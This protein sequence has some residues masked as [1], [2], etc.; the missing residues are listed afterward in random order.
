MNAAGGPPRPGALSTAAAI[1][2]TL[3]L[4]ATAWSIA[5]EGIAAALC[6]VLTLA[7]L[8]RTRT[9]WPATPVNLAGIG[10]FVALLVV[11][12]CSLDRAHSLPVITK[13]L[14]PLLVGLGAIHGRD[15]RVAE[16]AV[17]AYF[18]AFAIASVAGFAIWLSQ[19]ASFELRAR[20]LSGHYMTYAGQ[21]TLVLP[22]AIAI[23]VCDTR[24]RWRWGAGAT[25]AL[26]AVALSVTFTRSAWIALFVAGSVIA[27]AV[28]PLGLL[29][30][31]VLAGAAFAFAPGAWHER[32]WS[33][34]DPHHPA[35]QQRMYM[36][37]AGVRMFRDHPLTGV[38]LQ[39][40]HPL[41][42]RYRS[43][44]STER[45]GHLHNVYVQIAA[46]M[47]LVGL[48]AFAWLYG[49]FVRAASAGLRAQLKGRGFAAGL[50]L[51]VLASLAGFLVAGAFEWNFGSE[52]LL[53]QLYTLVGL[54][55]AARA[56]DDGQ[57]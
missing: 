11:S 38:G 20:G 23:A 32:L 33:I 37:D 51:G 2:F 43:P 30:L 35:N 53:Y 31:A 36:W 13:G 5:P 18:A 9:P 24:P 39:D 40:L 10:W 26:A 21:L 7:M 28:W 54:A 1:A 57:G 16:R 12:L 15:R 34:F 48:A 29:V 46:Q 44:L 27:G 19:G 55:W 4:V 45:A 17:A 49:S 8:A 22:V 3:L 47:G 25:A 41:Y 42:D 14:F 50:R 56:W 6:G 52:V